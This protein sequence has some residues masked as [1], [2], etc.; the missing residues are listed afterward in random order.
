MGLIQVT[1]AFLTAVSLAS[2]YTEPPA[3]LERRS[4]SNDT[5]RRRALHAIAVL[6]DRLYI[7]GGEISTWNETDG[8]LG[9]SVTQNST[10]YVSLKSSWTNATVEFTEIDKDEPQP[11]NNLMLWAGAESDTLYRWGGDGTYGF[12]YLADDIHL[13]ALKDDAWSEKLASNDDFFSD[14]YSGST[15]GAAV[16]DDM[17]FYVGGYGSG[18][19]D[20][21]LSDTVFPER[22]PLPGMLTYNMTERTWA[23]EST[24]PLNSPTGTWISGQALCVPGFGSSSLVFVIGGQTTPRTSAARVDADFT[25]F[26]NIT[27]YDPVQKEWYWQE[28]SGDVPRGRELFCAVG[29]QGK[30]TYDIYVYGGLDRA[31]GTLSDVSVLSIPSFQWFSID[32]SSPPRMHHACALVGKSQMLVSGGITGEWVWD[33]PDPWAQALGVFDL[34]TWEWSDKYDADA[35]AYDSPDTI[36]DWYNKGNYYSVDWSSDAV[37]EMFGT[38]TVFSNSSSSSDS[39]SDS[40]SDSDSSSS[41]SS[42]S[43]PVGAIAGG[44]IGGVAVLALAG[45]AFFLWRRKQRKN[46]ATQP[47]ELPPGTPKQELSSETQSPTPKVEEVIPANPIEL[48]GDREHKPIELPG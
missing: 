30:D 21:R 33:Q 46:A 19:T 40:G 1:A 39:D 35:A 10:L 45:V 12:T 41:S 14:I 26:S 34:K 20:E 32:V 23:N 42:S 8:T 3:K 28:A 17:G 11:A 5:F 25:D 44:T 4:T 15:G 38:A 13:W 24:V 16:C 18:S 2:G 31:T 43:T 27:F 37:K 36:L 47:Q 9:L 48:P 6:D 22:M 7:E 29:V